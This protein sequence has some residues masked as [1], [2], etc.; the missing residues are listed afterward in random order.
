MPWTGVDLVIAIQY[1][2][3]LRRFCTKSKHVTLVCFSKFIFLHVLIVLEDLS[4]KWGALQAV[5]CYLPSVHF[6][7]RAVDSGLEGRGGLI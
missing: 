2:A 5:V 3:I 1:M 4:R 7:H 6:L